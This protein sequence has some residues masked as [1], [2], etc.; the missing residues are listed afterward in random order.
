MRRERELAL[1]RWRLEGEDLVG[2]PPKK[3]ELRFS[4][5]AGARSPS[6][7]AADHDALVLNPGEGLVVV[8][9]AEGLDF[10]EAIGI[11]EVRE[12]LGDEQDVEAMFEAEAGQIVGEIPEDPGDRGI[13]LRGGVLR[14]RKS[15]GGIGFHEFL[16]LEQKVLAR[17]RDE[18]G[19]DGGDALVGGQFERLAGEV[20]DRAQITPGDFETASTAWES[21]GSCAA[22]AARSRCCMYSAVSARL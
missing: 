6:N 12:Q 16:R 7:P 18:R 19:V 22:P 13:R 20:V 21:N 8:V 17:G 11:G 2:L 15:R 9:P 4:V 3:Q 14:E 1:P 5:I 10:L